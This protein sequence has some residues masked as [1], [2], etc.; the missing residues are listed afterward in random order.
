[1][2]LKALEHLD[3]AMQYEAPLSDFTTFRL[4]GNC[5]ALITCQ[6]PDQIEKTARF[7]ISNN[8]PFILIGNGSNMVVSDQ[9][10]REYVIR[11]VS[12][13][14]I[15]ERDGNDLIV[16][17]S[18]R[19]DALGQYAGEQGL[20]GLSDMNGIPGTVAGAVYGNAGA[21]GKQIGD[22]IAVVHALDRKGRKKELKPPEL[23]F[24]YRHSNLKKTG[25]IVVSVR[26]SLFPGDKKTLEKR[27]KEVLKI[28]WEK[29][30]DL[31]VYPC[32]GSFF[33]NIEPTSKAGKREAAGW[34][35]EQAGAL[36][37][38]SGGAKVFEHHANMIYKSKG[39]RAQD[40]YDLSRLMARAV[41]EKFGLDLIREV[42]FVGKFN[43]MPA[44]VKN[45]IW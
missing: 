8:L 35:L 30:P 17:G 18:T 27:R 7:F 16:S 24:S 4:G 15:I 1:L 13:T 10:I 42:S 36:Q 33:R 31:S 25:D 40:V 44:N 37:M 9:G 41:K 5:P 3:V 20:E 2:D 45:I 11:Y 32:A 21:F 12:E 6:T 22:V 14:P 28:R 23:G 38:S 19:L 39:C 26:F 34:F 29:H 43:G